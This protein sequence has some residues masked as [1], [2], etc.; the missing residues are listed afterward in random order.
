M[1]TTRAVKAAEKR[2]E[3]AYYKSCSGIQIS[4]MDIGKVFKA[5]RE[6]IFAN[7]AISEDELQKVVFDFVQ[8][9]RKN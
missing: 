1:N 6:A 2:T 4:V 9:I 5:G 8:T 7:P 3:K